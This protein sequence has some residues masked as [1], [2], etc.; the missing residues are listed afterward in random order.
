MIGGFCEGNQWKWN[1]AALASDGYIYYIPYNSDYILQIDSR[2]TTEQILELIMNDYAG[3][4]HVDEDNL[5]VDQY[6]GIET[7]DEQKLCMTK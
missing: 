6:I 7:L 2:N 4:E 5:Y 1:G 3:H